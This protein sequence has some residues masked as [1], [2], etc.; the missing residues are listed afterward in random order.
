MD[1][2]GLGYEALCAINPRLIY[3][4]ISGFGQTGP[5]RDKPS[6]DIVTQAMSGA[7]S[8]NGEKGRPPVKLGL[9]IGDMVGGV[10]GPIT[11]LTALHERSLTGRGR[12]IDISLRWSYWHARLSRCLS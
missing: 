4:S 9:P 5:L 1:K 11:I 7:L 12:L 2:L 8:I 3:C 10:Y 6:F